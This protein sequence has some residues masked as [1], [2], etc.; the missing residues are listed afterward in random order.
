MIHFIRTS[1]FSKVLSSYLALQLILM[2]VQPMQLFALTSG[3]SQPEFNSFTPIGTSDMVSLASGDFNYNIPIM[4]VGGYPLNLAYDSGITMDQEA[5][6]VGLGWN[7]NVGQISRQ[8]RGLPDDFDGDTMTYETST[9]PNTT[10]G[11]NLRINPQIVGVEVG[12]EALGELSFGLSVQYNNYEGISFKPS[13]GISF[14]INDNVS[15]GMDVSTSTAEG[16]SISPHVSLD[17]RLSSD[18]KSSLNGI[19]SGLGLGVG[20]NSRQGLTSLNLSTSVKGLEATK[21]GHFKLPE[22]YRS[23]IGGSGTISF[24]NN[25]FTPSKRD[26]YVNQSYTFSA[27]IG[28]DF[29]GIDAEV[30]L[31]AFGSSQKIKDE[32]KEERGYGYEYTHKATSRDILDF[33]RAKDR[34]ISQNTLALPAVNY[35]YDL[36]S[37]N[38]QGIGGMFR[39]YRGQASYVFDQLV[40]DSSFSGS[41]GGE[42]EGTSGFHLGVDLKISPSETRT[43]VWNTN[44][45]SFFRPENPANNEMDYEDVYF[46]TIGEMRVDDES[47]LFFEKLGG[48]DPI[49]VALNDSPNSFGR[50][51]LNKFNKKG[52]TN[53]VP[54]YT[55]IPENGFTGKIKRTHRERKNRSVTKFTNAEVTAIGSSSLITPNVN[56]KEAHTAGMHILQPDGATYV[57]GETAYNINKQ[58]VTF[59]V[60]SNDSDNCTTGLVNYA[61]NSDNTPDN[62]KGIDNYF[63]KITTPEYAHTYLLTAVLSNDYEDITGDGPTDDDLG[64]YTRFI[65]ET[66]DND[67]KWRTPYN[68]NRASYNE[69]L[70]TN[71]FDQKGNYIYGE[72]ELKY[73]SRIE[74]KTHVAVFDLSERKDGHGVDDENGGGN[75]TS[76]PMYKINTISLYSKPEYNLLNDNDNTN[77]E[78]I[79]PIKVAHFEYD[80]SL[81]KEVPNNFGEAPDQHE[82]YSGSNEGGK[83]SLRKVFFTYRNSNMGKYTPYIFNYSDFNPN[84]NLKGYDVWG[85]YKENLGNCS[86]QGATI[87][88]AE[89]PFVN[90]EDRAT[91]DMYAAAWSLNAIDLPSGGKL[92]VSYETDDY[93]FV[94]DRRA[95]QMFK[96][97]GVTKEDNIPHPD[98]L[99]PTNRNKLYNPDN[100]NE[101]A[102]Y[103]IVEL[104]EAE[105][106][107]FSFRDKYLGG[108]E[109]KPIYYRFLSNMV[110]GESQSYDYVSGYFE[111]DTQAALETTDGT[112]N[113]YYLFSNEG[114][115]YGAIRM[116]FSDLEGGVN[117][118]KNVNPISKAS[119]YFA[120][121]YLNRQAYG[122]ELNPGSENIGDIAYGLISSLGSISEIFTGP[123]ESLR[124]KQC[125][126]LFNPDKSWIRLQHSG[127][128]KLGGGLRVK[129]IT[130]NDQWDAMLNANPAEENIKYYTSQYGQEYDYNLADGRSSGVATYEPNLSKENPFIEPFYN[131]GERLVAPR[132]VSYVEKPFGESFF[133]SPTVTYRQVSVKNLER[134][135]GDQAISK[136]ATGKVVNTFYT[137]YDFPTKT[138][139]TQLFPGGYASNENDIGASVL[140]GLLGQTVSTRTELAMSQGFVVETND[141]N[142]KQRSQKVYSESEAFI[143]GVDYKYNITPQGDLDSSVPVVYEDGEVREDKEVGTHYDVVTDF[144]ESFSKSESFGINTNVATF[145]VPFPPFVVVIPLGLPSHSTH[146]KTAHTT[147]TTKVIHKTGILKEKI[148]YDLGASVSTENVAWDAASGQILLTKTINEYD[149]QYYNFSFPA[150]WYYKGMDKASNNIGIK[151]TLNFTDSESHIPGRHLFTLQNVGEMQASDIFTLGDELFTY[152]IDE[153]TGEHILGEAE[154]LWVVAIE[155][156]TVTLMNRT[157]DVVNQTCSDV[158]KEYNLDFRIARS[159]YR[160]LHTAS[161]AS[162]TSQANPII[163]ANGGSI[164]NPQIFSN[165]ESET[166]ASGLKF[167]NASAIAYK[168][169]WELQAEQGLPPFPSSVGAAFGSNAAA[170]ANI[171]PENYGFNPYVYN[172]L[173]DWRAVNSYAHLTGRN[174]LDN[175][176]TKVSPRQQG[177]FN[178]FTSYYR[179]NNDMWTVNDDNWTFASR[180]TQYS[181]YGAELENM[182]ALNRYSSAQYGYNYTLP[183][184]VASNSTYGQIGYDSFEDYY[185]D[186]NDNNQ[187]AHFAMASSVNTITDTQ[188]HSGRYSIR[189]NGGQEAMLTTVLQADVFEVEQP[190][191]CTPINDIAC[192]GSFGDNFALNGAPFIDIEIDLSAIPNNATNIM[193][194][195]IYTHQGGGPPT[196]IIE[197]PVEYFDF[198]ENEETLSFRYIRGEL[199]E[200]T[201]PSFLHQIRFEFTYVLSGGIADCDIDVDI[202]YANN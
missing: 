175:T 115:H 159:G 37:I 172:A 127:D 170:V 22:D 169:Y 57:Y 191:D 24:V 143:S 105:E 149:D 64:A 111:V 176:I 41:L 76:N 200:G 107:V 83:L 14:A 160:N 164:L 163:N 112:N 162:I 142:G 193:I 31:D 84:Y 101:D 181:P 138:D 60:G 155:G 89:F 133:P 185:Y 8:V 9:K 183:T 54:T 5:S 202:A 199:I 145:L 123:N 51:G 52:Y 56:A 88:A 40:Q 61:P 3:P 93:Q 184:A 102:R 121:Q 12:A 157:G 92:D 167:I 68:S 171:P 95:M 194:D 186:G 201:N 156:N 120:R 117:G 69:G 161:M 21:L 165:T 33:N 168:G 148:A 17:R 119:W 108:Q 42:V 49:S 189:V 104:P 79:S 150:H 178:S 19:S 80:Y 129:K 20:F 96:I 124:N 173:G 174:T 113:R 2:T 152:G 82:N 55:S 38:G 135:D 153:E 34:I 188:S 109:H 91:Q 1:R 139:Y 6:W 18:K 87:P 13:Y 99:S 45:T 50:Y 77:D 32:F 43:G 110:V 98:D 166:D 75:A 67:F 65:Y 190:E 198:N 177:F 140:A 132:E 182:D 114:K 146:E 44:A 122:L 53:N 106:S 16:V 73:I 196:S 134:V 46:K 154:K 187:D 131:T 27:S 151:G 23:K 85:N 144:R 47:E 74:T 4:D 10:V 35:T 125:G 126:R 66:K 26:A 180:V 7:L 48:Y 116:K 72:K 39:P 58:E 29:W 70:K 100:Y 11:M 94:Q 137:S 147:T 81:C 136:H 62:D 97:A 90:Q 36:Y 179:L 192:V 195:P 128:R 86:I 158:T 28:P 141:M 118:T 103:L 25:T 71:I 59:A 15:V 197:E 30:G 63:N 130:L 78:G